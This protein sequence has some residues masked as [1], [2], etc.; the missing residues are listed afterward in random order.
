MSAEA[1][2]VKDQAEA[3]N[4]IVPENLKKGIACAI[5]EFIGLLTEDFEKDLGL[6]EGDSSLLTKSKMVE[7]IH[8]LQM[9]T[10][11]WHRFAANPDS[12][13]PRFASFT[14]TLVTDERTLVV[15]QGPLRLPT[16]PTKP[17][18]RIKIEVRKVRSK[19]RPASSE[20]LKRADSYRGMSPEKVLWRA[21]VQT[22]PPSVKLGISLQTA[23]WDANRERAIISPGSG[24]SLAFFSGGYYESRGLG[25]V[26][27]TRLQT[28]DPLLVSEASIKQ[29]DV[30]FFVEM[31]SQSAQK[32]LAQSARKK[33]CH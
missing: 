26:G 5:E 23:Y 28:E 17:A 1:A 7:A 16:N 11:L 15:D 18:R 30:L 2:S 27:K 12:F 3:E 25:F 10:D 4:K 21:E 31:L 19:I 6:G 13:K 14:R 22:P 29:E 33:R 32:F 24:V 8:S 20:E 9:L